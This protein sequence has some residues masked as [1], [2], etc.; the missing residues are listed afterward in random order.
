MSKPYAKYT[1]AHLEFLEKHCK[2]LTDKDL[3]A[4][5]NKTFNQ[6]RTYKGIGAARKR[7]GIKSGRCGRFKPGN[8]PHPNA[9]AKGPNKTSFKKGL[10]PHNYKPIGT[11]R[12][13]ED[14]LVQ[15]KVADP[16]RWRSK[17]ALIWEKHHGKPVP[18]GSIIRFADGN[19]RN[20]NPENL[21]LVTRAANA[22]YNKRGYNKAP[23]EIKPTLMHVAKLDAVIS[24]RQSAKEQPCK[25]HHT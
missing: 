22:L 18:K 4:L 24:K 2:S 3:A 17:H 11:E 25:T 5:F 1:Q 7:Y 6:N 23:T 16:N 12:T 10:T 13:T 9:G 14:N 8:I 21:V 15:I 19:Q 20:F